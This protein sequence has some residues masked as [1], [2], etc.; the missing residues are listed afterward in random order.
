MLVE[1]C[2]C[3]AAYTFAIYIKSRP[4]RGA[5]IEDIVM[6]DLEISGAQGGFL[7]LN[8]LDSGKQDPFP[9]PGMDGVPTVRSF[10]FER[11]QVRDAPVLVE[12]VNIHPDKPLDG[13]T[14]KNV[15]GTSGRGMTL[16]NMRNV[17]LEH[18]DV[19]VREGPKLAIDNVREG[20]KLAID[21]VTGR[22]L[23]GA[24]RLQPTARPASVQATEPPYQ[25]G[26]TT[27]RPN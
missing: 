26:A 7:R 11:I 14:L 24:A 27:G 19:E 21:N 20:P 16:A 5:F 1:R 25:F 22:G 23:Q 12:A 15:T 3:L 6:R 17:V 2:R 18:V 10:T 8:F 4:G 13:F 9:V